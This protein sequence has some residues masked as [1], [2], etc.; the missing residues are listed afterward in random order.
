M[1]IKIKIYLYNIY[2]LKIY[3]H[4]FNAILFQLISSIVLFKELNK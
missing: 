4:K 3:K 2:I 1:A